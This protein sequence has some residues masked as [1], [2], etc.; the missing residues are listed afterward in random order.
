M[1]LDQN[2]NQDKTSALPASPQT[3]QEVS[4]QR[5]KKQALE[6]QKIAEGG[7]SEPQSPPEIKPEFEQLSERKAI[8]SPPP[9]PEEAQAAPAEHPLVT[10]QREKARRAL[11]EQNAAVEKLE[12][13]REAVQGTQEEIEK[14]SEKTAAKAEL[15]AERIEKGRPQ[16]VEAARQTQTAA[17]KA[18]EAAKDLK[19]EAREAVAEQKEVAGAEKKAQVEVQ[20]FKQLQRLDPYAQKD[21]LSQ[22][23]G[24]KKAA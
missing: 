19:Q 9:S 14:E 13:A 20:K 2:Q 18:E 1:P 23:R 16:G 17:G 7:A 10:I 21:A 4:E 3:L 22:G 24:E 8:T 6:G 15:S 5:L 12:M 11:E